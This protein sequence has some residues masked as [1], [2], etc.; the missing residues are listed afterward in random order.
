MEVTTPGSFPTAADPRDLCRSSSS[1]TVEGEPL[2]HNRTAAPKERFWVLKLHLV[3]TMGQAWGGGLATT[4]P[5]Q[6]RL[7]PQGG[8]DYYGPRPRHMSPFR[9][10]MHYS[11]ERIRVFD[12]IKKRITNNA[13][14]KGY[15]GLP[16]NEVLSGTILLK[17]KTHPM[18]FHDV[19]VN[20]FAAEASAVAQRPPDRLTINPITNQ[21]ILHPE[22]DDLTPERVET[23]S[24]SSGA[25]RSGIL[26]CVAGRWNVRPQR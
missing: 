11:K 20:A 15:E 1:I 25:C 10:N 26:Q 12:Q 4:W 24:P 23:G 13:G 7:V 16:H 8:H 3:P 18:L 9:A 6:L 17:A 22:A 19:V 21:N 5:P 14:D 2:D